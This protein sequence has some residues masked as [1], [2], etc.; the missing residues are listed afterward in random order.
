MIHFKLVQYLADRGYLKSNSRMMDVGTQNLMFAEEPQ[1]IEFIRKLRHSPLSDS[2]VDEI[3]RLC[4]FST[5]RAG[6]RTSYLHELLAFTDASYDSIDIVDGLKTTI[7]DLNFDD[8]PQRWLKNFD[9]LINCG[10]LEHVINQYKAIT[11]IHDVLKV[12]GVWF[13]QPPSVGF[14]NHGYYNYNP[15]F[16]LDLAS[17]NDYEI[18]EAW[19]SHGGTYPRTDVRFPIVSVA[20]LDEESERVNTRKPPFSESDKRVLEQSLSYNFNVAMKKTLDAPLRLPL[21]I[22][23]THAAADKSKLTQYGESIF[24]SNSRK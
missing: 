15:L 16:Y 6:E 23:T 13:D 7:F 20:N 11:F 5:P 18:I 17:A 9:I 12:G 3:R 14:L 22:R 2:D 19:Y 21:E 24:D 1:A 10:T 8:V 4:Y